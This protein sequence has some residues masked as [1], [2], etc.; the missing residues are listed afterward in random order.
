MTNRP[1]ETYDPDAFMRWLRI[2]FA[3]CPVRWRDDTRPMTFQDNRLGSDEI[4]LTPEVFVD[5][6]EMQIAMAGGLD[7]IRII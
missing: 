1:T 7:H 3:S 4:V 2:E 5:I 6:A